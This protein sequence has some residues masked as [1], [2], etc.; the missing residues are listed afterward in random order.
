[1]KAVRVVMYELKGNIDEV[2]SRAQET[3]VPIYRGHAG[4]ESLS[5]VADADKIISI[6]H[7]DTHEHAEEGSKAVLE[8]VDQQ[9]DVIGAPLDRHIGDEVMS[10]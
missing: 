6:S 5:V 10:V 4:F 1:M 9:S 2:V 7:W 3:L 8:W